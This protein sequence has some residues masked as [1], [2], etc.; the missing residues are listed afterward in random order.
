MGDNKPT[1]FADFKARQN[2]AH[3]PRT[4]GALIIALGAQFVNTTIPAQRRKQTWTYRRFVLLTYHFHYSLSMETTRD[5]SHVSTLHDC[6]HTL[7]SQ[8]RPDGR[9][10]S[11]IAESQCVLS[12]IGILGKSR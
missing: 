7:C 11:V 1:N 8:K 12:R 4:V 10:A 2:V 5:T 6:A 9:Y 3:F